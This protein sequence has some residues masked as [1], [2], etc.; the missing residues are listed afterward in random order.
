MCQNEIYSRGRVDKHFFF[1]DMFPI[2]IGLN[3][4][5]ALSPLLLNFALE[6]AI[7]KVHANWWGGYIK[8]KGT[9][10]KTKP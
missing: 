5:D 10:W 6:Y 4:G 9:T 1:P 2:K 3:Q 8:W 7:R